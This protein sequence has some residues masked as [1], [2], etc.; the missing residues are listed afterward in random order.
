MIA[1][2]LKRDGHGFRFGPY[3]IEVE[4]GT[5]EVIDTRLRKGGFNART[6]VRLPSLVAVK[7]WLQ[8]RPEYGRDWCRRC[9]AD[10]E[11]VL[12]NQGT[13]EACGAKR[14]KRALGPHHNV[15]PGQGRRKRFYVYA[16]DEERHWLDARTLDE[17]MSEVRDGDAAV[18]GQTVDIYG[19]EQWDDDPVAVMV[20]VE[21]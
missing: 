4:Y 13:C 15:R 17:A 21:G 3:W 18:L 20:D 1:V 12:D 19:S 10:P 14:I 8:E 16:D 2:K 6:V 9:G 11:T 5:V 7:A